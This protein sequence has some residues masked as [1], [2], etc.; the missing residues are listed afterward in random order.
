MPIDQPVDVKK[1]TIH[2]MIPGLDNKAAKR[3]GKLKQISVIGLGIVSILGLGGYGI[4]YLYEQFSLV[5]AIIVVLITAA[6]YFPITAYLVRKWSIQ[7]NKKLQ[8]V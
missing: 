5:N 3:I 7:W 8:S 2:A 6:V 4:L 1:Q